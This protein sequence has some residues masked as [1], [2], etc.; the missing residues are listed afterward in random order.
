MP[1]NDSHGEWIHLLR[2][3]HRYSGDRAFAG[4]HF[5]S[6]ERA[7]AYLDRLRAERRT[8]EY[9]RGAARIFFGLLPQSISHEGYSEK[10]MHSY[11]DDAFGYLG[12]DDA[13][14]LAQDLGRAELARRWRAS[15][16]QFRADLVASI[17]LV[18]ARQGIDYLPGSA[19]LG[20]FDATSSTVLLEPTALAEALPRAA[21]EA[22]FERYWREFEERRDG[23]RAW[24]VYTPYELRAVGVFARLGWRDRAQ[25]LLDFFL[26]GRRPAAW[27]QWP[28][29]VLRE[30]RRP[31]FLGDLPHGWVASD[32]A[33]SLLDLY[34]YERRGDRA[35][36]LAAGIPRAWLE[37][38][39]EVGVRQL[40]TPWGGLSYAMRL[41]EGRLEAEIS[42]LAA[43]PPGGVWLAPPLGDS[44]GRVSVDGV[45]QDPAREIALHRLPA[46]VVVER[47]W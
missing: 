34:A 2:E 22:T 13:Q 31:R 25:Q 4:R 14:A 6:V 40:R 24:D 21:L 47:P 7:A 26:A 41:R 39:E 1:E 19:E 36:V 3:V 38:G 33:R 32:F 42:G 12:Y 23:R 18:Q 30:A 5:A 15:R 8:A 46:R 9:S 11:W 45:S 27:N 28:E 16:E 10:P 17:G 35:L 20:D 29:V 37:R 43:P 44:P